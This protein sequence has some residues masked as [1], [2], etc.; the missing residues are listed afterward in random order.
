MTFQ[1][2]AM[3]RALNVRPRL[4]ST[5]SVIQ[6]PVKTHRI[7]NTILALSSTVI[8]VY[9]AGVYLSER[10][11]KYKD[12]V[13]KT[14][15][16]SDIIIKNYEICSNFIENNDLTW[17]NIK[18]YIMGKTIGIPIH[19]PVSKTSTSSTTTTT[20][21]TDD[22]KNDDKSELK[23]II[24][25]NP[26]SLET[27]NSNEN[28]SRI[29]DS[30]NNIIQLINERGKQG[31][32]NEIDKKTFE[33]AFQSVLN[34]VQLLNN[35][36]LNHIDEKIFEGIK[37]KLIELD[38]SFNE[39]IAKKET[40]IENKYNLE[41]MK[42]KED[43]EEKAAQTLAVGLSANEAKLR[44][45]NDNEI[46]LLSIT[47]VDEF[48]KIV[49]DKIESERN[50]KL[51]NLL[52]LDQRVN[53][54]NNTIDSI[55]NLVIRNTIKNKLT[56]ILK[57]IQDE[58]YSFSG[59]IDRITIHKQINQLKLIASILPSKKD[60]TINNSIE[61]D[62]CRCCS[63]GEKATSTEI[64]CSKK[65]KK[66]N[67]QT[68]IESKINEHTSCRCSMKNKPTLLET[69]LN[70]LENI[71]KDQPI[72]S[73]EQ[74]YNRW[75]LLAQD[76]KTASLLSSDSGFFRHLMAKLFSLLLFT[77][78]G[79]QPELSSKISPTKLNDND[80]S[81]NENLS[82]VYSRIQNNIKLSNLEDAV[83]DAVQ[84][85]GWTRALCEDWIE[86]ARRK[87]EFETLLQVLNN[88]VKTL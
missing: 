64:C 50:G 32:T 43:L 62:N 6:P 45:K 58:L 53:K 79:S 86:D 57:S 37:T 63:N 19:I 39:S 70:E 18:S 48:N 30:L 83:M 87:L 12:F 60:I 47:Q 80:I 11:P 10:D 2:T 49:T 3:R 40:E 56:T 88:E 54:F 36:Y 61:K 78:N 71:T 81:K 28:L 75:S 35:T 67:E 26:V 8:T 5:G 31:I 51:K 33:N 7:R 52:E 13:V 20:T 24:E 82:I 84:L 44:A 9:S 25:L 16:S 76:F 27:D 14:L 42:F 66:Q 34:S 85:D 4:Y 65:N 15:P 55:D 72:L 23:P 21:T 68:N 46:A 41:F 38:T 29:V 59:S 69:T 22:N 1:K 77:K 74:L 73:N 17:D